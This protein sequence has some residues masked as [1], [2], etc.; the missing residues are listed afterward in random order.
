MSTSLTLIMGSSG[1]VP[2]SPAVVDAALIELVTAT[3]PGYTATLPGSLIEDVSSTSVAAILLCG[4]AQIDLVNSV[5]PLGANPFI[6]NQL[7]QIYGV[8]L[9]EATNTSVNVVFNGPPGYVLAEGFIVGDG[10]NQYTLSDGGICGSDGNSAPLFALCTVSGSFA[11]PAGTVT[12]VL[13]AVPTGITLTVNNPQ[14]GTPGAGAET[15]QSYRGRVIQAGLAIAQGMPTFL[16]TLLGNVSGVQPRLISVRQI[17][18]GGWEI[19]VGG[20]DPYFVAYAIYKALF[21]ISTLVG[22]VIG[23]STISKA[24][25]ASVVTTLNHGYVTGELVTLIDCQGMT[26]INGVQA[27]VTVI[28]EKTFTMAINSTGFSTYTG[29]G[30]ATPN[31]RN[32]VVS[33]IDTPDTYSI[34]YVSPPQQSVAI[35]LTW[36]TTS[37]NPVS[38]VAMAQLGGPALQN[39]V[40]G[41]TNADGTVYPGIS[42]GQPM[43]LFE[44]Q[45]VF[46]QAVAPLLDPQL[47]TRM[48]FAVSIDG[49]GVAPETG[50]G[51]IAGD[52]ESFLFVQLSDIDIAQG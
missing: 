20:G 7:G 3:N 49:V 29:G 21:D 26:Q 37:D 39:Y 47:L 41:G 30:I 27:A 36:N 50:T 18:G 5:T 1:P 13:T 43:N 48:V 45:A 42:S 44:L 16:K 40:N 17:D 34:P 52:P 22:S 35:S 19:I 15:E 25:A 51:I 24:A 14:S 6:L 31:S 2:Q 4:A 11:V 23:V 28:D 46:Q 12:Q 10:T 8:A 33:I 32:V 38:N 9:G